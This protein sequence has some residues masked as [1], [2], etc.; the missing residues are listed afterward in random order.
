[1]RWIRVNLFKDGLWFILQDLSIFD[2][3]SS[4]IITPNRNELKRMGEALGI[5]EK[6]SPAQVSE[7]LNNCWVM[8]KDQT[9]IVT[10]SKYG[11]Y[12]SWYQNLLTMYLVLLVWRA[13]RYLMWIFSYSLK[14]CEIPKYAAVSLVSS[15]IMRSL[16]SK[17]YNEKGIGMITS[18]LINQIP[19][20]LT[21]LTESC[22]S[23]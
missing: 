11:N 13:R 16:C 1:M 18:D 21:R 2:I 19:Y 5:S 14:I 15:Y 4:I 7:R 8:L 6:I 3:S 17:V 12:F 23:V 20:I 22:K 9:D 10:N